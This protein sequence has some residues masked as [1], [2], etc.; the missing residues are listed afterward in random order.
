M[1]ASDITVAE[2]AQIDGMNVASQRAELGTVVEEV[3]AIAV[4]NSASIITLEGNT[5]TIRTGSMAATLSHV[6]ASA[7]EILTGTTGIIGYLVD[8]HIGGSGAPTNVVNS[9]SNL[10]V[11]PVSGSLTNW[12]VVAVDDRVDWLVF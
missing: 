4:A 3:Q 5:E 12:Q 2:A 8:V 1:T 11:K 10:L 6:D 7:I 9:G